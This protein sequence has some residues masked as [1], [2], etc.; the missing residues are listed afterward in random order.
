MSELWNVSVVNVFTG[1][2]NNLNNDFGS[3]C[4]CWQQRVEYMSDYNFLIWPQWKKCLSLWIILR[5]I[6][7]LWPPVV[8]RL[9]RTVACAASEGAE[10]D[11]EGFTHLK[12]L[13][14]QPQRWKMAARRRRRRGGWGRLGRGHNPP[15]PRFSSSSPLPS[16]FSGIASLHISTQIALCKQSQSWCRESVLN[17]NAASHAIATF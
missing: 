7:F 8:V 17:P 12:A 10:A 5:A 9:C 15:I 14:G 16:L 2:S 3:E 1:I 4:Q 11:V 13:E 6:S